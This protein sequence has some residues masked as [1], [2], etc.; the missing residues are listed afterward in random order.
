MQQQILSGARAWVS[1]F[2]IRCF[3]F[4][5]LVFRK[6]Y[7]TRAGVYMCSCTHRLVGDYAKTAESESLNAKER[8]KSLPMKC[9]RGP[10]RLLAKLM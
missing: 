10:F 3:G 5:A 1:S 7:S 6:A 2:V 4:A 8:D 9:R